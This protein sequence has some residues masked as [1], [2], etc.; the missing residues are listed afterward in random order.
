MPQP[1]AT[2][3]LQS[4]EVLRIAHEDARGAYRDLSCYRITLA[5]REEGW[6][7]EYELDRLGWNGGGPHYLIDGITGVILSKKYYQ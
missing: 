4:W 5:N 6:H 3:P 7:V 1:P 2:I